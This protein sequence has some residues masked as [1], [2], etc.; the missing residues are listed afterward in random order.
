M[1]HEKTTNLELVLLKNLPSEKIW[2]HCTQR[3]LKISNFDIEI[4]RVS[5]LNGWQIYD[6][7]RQIRVVNVI[8]KNKYLGTSFVTITFFI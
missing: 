8:E 7:F 1:R 6:L 2:E 4:K 3:R 5:S